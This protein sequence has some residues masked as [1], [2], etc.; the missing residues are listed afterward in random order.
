MAF[1]LLVLL[2][3]KAAVR[4]ADSP[5]EAEVRA[6]QQAYDTAWVRQDVA[7]FERLLAPEYEIVGE[8]GKV[9]TRN[10][11]LA[12]ARN[13]SLKFEIGES[14]DVRIVV[15][16]S[17]A[18]VRGLW[19]GKGANKAVPFDELTRYTTT[20]TKVGG[21]WKA[22]ADQLSKVS[23]S[24]AI[25]QM[26]QRYARG[27]DAAAAAVATAGWTKDAWEMAPHRPITKGRAALE[28]ETR[29]YFKLMRDDAFRYEATTLE[30]EQMGDW[31][32]NI[33]QFKEI[34]A[35]GTVVDEGM[36]MGLWKLEDGEWK[37]HRD[38]WNSSLPKQD[39]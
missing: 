34:K 35:D 3:T 18:V 37:L 28:A 26:N 27:G 29:A 39:K 21:Q 38:I 24:A 15:R 33:D 16:E 14:R 11:V 1:A 6:V 9:T 12:D 32:F 4:A 2:N 30:S 23:A 8:D 7:A 5:A 25:A 17:T 31:A 19:R 10:V 13:G 36:V 20:Y 22:L